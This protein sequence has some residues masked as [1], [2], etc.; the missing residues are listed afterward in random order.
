MSVTFLKYMLLFLA[1][2][3][4]DNKNTKPQR[5]TAGILRFEEMTVEAEEL[6]AGALVEMPALLDASICVSTTGLK[7]R[8]CPRTL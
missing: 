1:A 2:D 6:S 3:R 5:S 8:Q 7:V 4:P